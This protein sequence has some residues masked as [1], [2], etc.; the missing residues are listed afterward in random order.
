MRKSFFRF[1]TLLFFLLSFPRTIP[2]SETGNAPPFTVKNAKPCREITALFTGDTLWT[3]SDGAYSIPLGP[4]RTLWLF[5]D[6][7]I[8]AIENG[9]RVNPALINNTAA[10]QLTSG[11]KSAM[12]FYWRTGGGKPAALFS[13]HEDHAYYWPGDGAFVR[14]KLYLFMK[15]I[16]PL[17]EGPPG[18]QFQWAGDDL[19][20]IENPGMEPPAWAWK[21]IPLNTGSSGNHWGTACTVAGGHLFVYGCRDEGG[22]RQVL[23]ARVPLESLEKASLQRTEFWCGKAGWLSGDEQAEPLFRDGATEMTVSRYPGISGF[24]ALYTPMGLGPRVLLRHSPAPEGP[25]SIPLEIYAVPDSK[26]ILLYG[27]KGHPELSTRPGHLIIT[28]NRNNCSL[29]ED[30]IKPWIYFPQAVEVRLGTR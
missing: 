25:W 21:R 23:L 24:V 8:G 11:K 17:P 19:L 4:G 2:A 16:I 3:G 12:H 10:L 18:F 27:A 30:I 28:Y 5:G 20:V 15:K 26:G 6:T 7:Y 22:E 9:K 1:F 13:P 14:G 29:E